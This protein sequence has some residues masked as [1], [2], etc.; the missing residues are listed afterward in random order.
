MVGSSSGSLR[1]LGYH[2]F[3]NEDSGS[4]PL[5]TT[6]KSLKTFGSLKKFLY[7]CSIV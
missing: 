6:K 5:L 2:S 7:F 1:R 3:Q 4:N